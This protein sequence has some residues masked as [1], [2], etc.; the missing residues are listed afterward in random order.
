LVLGD[1]LGGLDWLAITLIAL[2]N[3]GAVLA[4]GAEPTS[5]TPSEPTALAS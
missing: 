1:A 2:A 5:S 4:S 3:V